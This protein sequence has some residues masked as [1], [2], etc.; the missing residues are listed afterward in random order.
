LIID[1]YSDYID[2]YANL[3]KFTL[4]NLD[5]F[6]GKKQLNII[7]VSCITEAFTLDE[8]DLFIK[9]VSM[10]NY[11]FPYSIQFSDKN[12]L[13]FRYSKVSFENNLVNYSVR[14]KMVIRDKK[15]D[16]LLV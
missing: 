5:E 7:S 15:I 3:P 9:R 8:L 6:E 16:S 1:N 11:F 13:L 12:L 14:K 4:L 10:D 2:D